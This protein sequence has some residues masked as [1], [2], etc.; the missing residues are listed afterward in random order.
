MHSRPP[1]PS[2][3]SSMEITPANLSLRNCLPVGQSF[4]W[5]RTPLV[6][7]CKPE[8]DAGPSTPPPPVVK[9]ELGAAVEPEEE[10]SRAVYDPP[11]V[12]CLRQTPDRIYYT[13]VHPTS[14][15][16]TQDEAEGTTTKWVRDYFHLDR[17]PDLA[18]MYDDWRDRDKEL[19][20]KV[21]LNERARGV[22]LLRQDPWE[23][24]IAYVP[25]EPIL[26][27]L[28]L[29]LQLYHLDEQP[30]SPDRIIDA[31]AVAAFQPTTARARRPRLD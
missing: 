22:R 26:G 5:H 3:W 14:S 20:G 27:G 31:Q 4:L 9:A 17:Y 10:F 16:Q 30:Y 24:L 13:A 1:F 15:A 8:A 23:C 12:V 18:A 19:F 7:A 6:G 29:T 11:R 21:E 25:A 2:G 28:K